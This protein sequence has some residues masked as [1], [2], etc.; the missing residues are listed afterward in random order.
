MM[1]PEPIVQNNPMQ[2]GP[3]DIGSRIQSIPVQQGVSSNYN[4][5]GIMNNQNLN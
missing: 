4:N 2:Q 1:N 3:N 5:N